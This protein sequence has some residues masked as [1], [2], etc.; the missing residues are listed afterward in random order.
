M[1]YRG[2]IST[3]GFRSEGIFKDSNTSPITYGLYQNDQDYGTVTGYSFASDTGTITNSNAFWTTD[4]LIGARILVWDSTKETYKGSSV[5]T[6][7]DGTTVDFTYIQGSDLATTADSQIVTSAG[8]T[9]ETD[10]VISGDIF[11][12]TTDAD[13]GNYIVHSV[14]S[15]TQL[16]LHK[17]LTATDTG[18]GFNSNF[19][20]TPAT[21]DKY[22]IRT[23]GMKVTD[24]SGVHTTDLGLL[25]NDETEL[26]DPEAEWEQDYG[27]GYNREPALT[28]Q[29]MY[30]NHG[31][32]S[33]RLR[34]PRILAFALGK[35]VVTGSTAPYTHVM[36]VADILPSMVIESVLRGNDPFIRYHRGCKVNSVKLSAAKNELLQCEAELYATKVEE[37]P[38]GATPS[39]VVL[40]TNSGNYKSGDGFLLN[41]AS[42]TMLGRPYLCLDSFEFTATNELTEDT[43][44]RGQNYLWPTKLYENNIAY[45]L[46]VAFRP[47]DPTVWQELVDPTNGGF[48]TELAFTRTTNYDTLLLQ[49]TGCRFKMAPHKLPNGVLS[50]E[51]DLIFD[52]VTVTSVD[53]KPTYF[54]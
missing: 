11:K 54:V 18:V 39:T 38:A 49:F 53:D 3:V 36:S 14:D 45:E 32:P 35:E 48:T 12:I 43:C 52:S 41:S 10:G 5:I 9:F 7:N 8:S 51:Q 30:K 29:K 20:A 1:T 37:A 6:D 24:T 28:T 44:A 25:F 47:S 33:G 50:V 34:V 46:K 22:E 27:V 15:E 13:A 26:P 42:F 4:R 23:L 40:D 17:A 2:N 19:N 16:T 21:S 31:T